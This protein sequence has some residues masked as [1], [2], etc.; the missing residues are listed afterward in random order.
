MRRNRWLQALLILLVIIA[1]LYLLQIL[2]QLG[3]RFAGV[4]ILFF[5][6][7]MIAFMLSPIVD[8]LHANRVP[9][10]LAV[11]LMYLALALIA[12]FFTLLAVPSL[13]DQMTLL[14]GNIP[15]YT[16]SLTQLTDSVHNEL[17]AQGVSDDY[18][19]SALQGAVTRLDTLST[20]VMKD[21]LSIASGIAAAMFNGILVLVLSFYMTL[22]GRNI[23]AKLL[24]LVPPRYQRSGQLFL[25]SVS[26]SFGGF[27]RTQLVLA[28]ITGVAT[29]VVMR[30]FGLGFILVVAL[31]CGI[32]TLVPLIGNIVA[33]GPPL[34]IAAFQ[35]PNKLT[36]LWVFIALWAVQQVLLNVVV[37]RLLSGSVGLHPLLIFFAMLFGASAT[38]AWGAIFGVPVVAVVFIMARHFYR[39]VLIHLPLYADVQQK[40]QVA[41]LELGRTKE[42][43]SEGER[44]REPVAP[45]T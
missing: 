17:A 13:V 44:A 1:S 14:A 18:L 33:L 21:S 42:R 38:G 2:W 39:D 43:L 20:V 10:L 30:V 31:V 29:G 36:V 25:D 24:T 8:V 5:L 11:V 26:Q 16:E 12:V 40:E 15:K 37:P 34:I 3:Q 45:A 32:V 6:A 7:W 28:I 9:R 27:L 19:V 23:V 22:D 4:G 35:A 41:A